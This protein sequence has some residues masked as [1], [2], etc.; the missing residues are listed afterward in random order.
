[1]KNSKIQNEYLKKI[2]LFQQYNKFYYD[3]SNPKVTDGEFDSL[4]KE[5]IE[6]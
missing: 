1:M 4:K 6:L 3:K 2:K 5:I